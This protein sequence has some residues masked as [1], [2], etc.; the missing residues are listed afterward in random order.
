MQHDRERRRIRQLRGDT[1]PSTDVMDQ[2]DRQRETRRERE[3]KMPSTL[4]HG[5]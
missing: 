2:P 5:A 4:T 1:K 3:A